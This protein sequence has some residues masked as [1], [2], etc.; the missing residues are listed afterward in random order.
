MRPAGPTEHGI[1]LQLQVAS[2]DKSGKGLR[3]HQQDASHVAGFV[4]A[5]S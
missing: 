2:A 1:H 3:R 5:G 4:S